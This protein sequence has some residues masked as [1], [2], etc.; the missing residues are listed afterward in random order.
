MP[1]QNLPSNLTSF[2]GRER[3]VANIARSLDAARFITL[4][5]SGGSG[6]T[7]L[8]IEVAYQALSNYPEGVWFVDLAA[9]TEPAL[10]VPTVAAVLEIREQADR[11]LPETLAEWLGGR[12]VL[13]VLDNC[14]HLVRAC[15]SLVDML[16]R[17]CPHIH[18]LATSRLVLNVA[19]ET[20]WRVPPMSYPDPTHLPTLETLYEYDAVSLFVERVR[21]RQP[22][23]HLT[24]QDIPAIAKLCY[25]L[26]GIPL[27]LEL[28]AARVPEMS[29]A[30]ITA[31]LD[32]RFSLLV[33]GSQ[34]SPGRQETLRAVIDSSYD[35]LSEEE[36]ELLQGLSA[37]AGGFS[38][39]AAAKICLEEEDQYEA[40]EMITRLVD[41]SLLTSEGRSGESRYRLLDTI[42][43]YALGKLKASGRL[44]A[45]R[46][47]HLSWY[48]RVA[49]EAEPHLQGPDQSSWLER[50]QIDHDN[51]RAALEWS[52]TWEEGTE[53]GLRLV[54]ALDWFWFV[55]NYLT[56]G[57]RWLEG[58]MARSE[59]EAPDL[60][61][62]IFSGAAQLARGQGDYEDAT[63]YFTQSLELYRT[64][65]DKKNVAA[66]LNNLGV[67]ATSQGDYERAMA[68][69][70]ESLAIKAELDDRNGV[71]IALN[72]LANLSADRGDY[73]EARRYLEESVAIQRVFGNRHMLAV[74]LNNLGYVAR[75]LGKYEKAR[76]YIEESLQIKEELGN[77]AEIASSLQKLAELE[78]CNHR[79]DE[80]RGL[81][82]RGLELLEGVG[83]RE[84]EAL[85]L[86]MLGEIARCEGDYAEAMSRY[87]EALAASTAGW[88]VP[89]TQYN[90]GHAAQQMGDYLQ[91]VP[92]LTESLNAY[93]QIGSG[94][95]IAECLVCV[96]KMALAHDR[97]DVAAMLF[98]AA[99][100]LLE[101]TRYKMHPK[102][103]E[104]LRGSQ[105]DVRARL[106]KKVWSVAYAEGRA[107]AP[108][109]ASGLAVE[110]MQQVLEATLER[111]SVGKAAEHPTK[112]FKDLTRR[113]LEVLR[114]V[115]DGLK[116]TVIAE[117]LSLSPNTVHAHL[118][119]IYVKLNVTTRSAAARFAIENGLV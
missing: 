115:A 30:E 10:V 98:G 69:I 27:A 89:D 73:S 33:A 28:A 111:A 22:D 92:C 93:M 113:E 63:R 106:G 20:L 17:K 94:R 74:S 56:E 34:R 100:S 72:N 102:D 15:A 24:Q 77:R 75:C 37:F 57:R 117:Q 71:S 21:L 60:R 53:P 76:T 26:D 118:R 67:V 43:Q 65:D 109:V 32:E 91:A 68:V 13:L 107:M 11:S 19:G 87:E 97:N 25:G 39:E 99:S 62:A 58:A 55:R 12:K 16:L 4:T 44:P 110:T 31:R 47:R 29:L 66:T 105:R 64:L 80:A 70:K 82:K 95:G 78:W 5:G 41:A 104:D 7:R 61:A 90:R 45:V 42:R 18:I 49:E 88:I 83:D 86:N 46:S 48:V 84:T 38:L 35:L 112:Y 108:S 51:F 8:S 79:Y 54:K 59:G 36:Q 114:L 116:D 9:L 101:A 119:S 14:E 50:L 52:Q 96:A 23:F 3:E 2:I 40:I 1:L 81:C 6:K 85:L 103:S